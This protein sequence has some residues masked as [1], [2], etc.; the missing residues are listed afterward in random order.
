MGQ[1]PNLIKGLSLCWQKNSDDVGKVTDD[2]KLITSKLFNNIH[3]F[4]LLHLDL[5]REH[6]V[7]TC[8]G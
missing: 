5:C 2:A 4:A 3:L 7:V 1:Y 8:G 6:T